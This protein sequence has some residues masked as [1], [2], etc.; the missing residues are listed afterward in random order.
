M[1]HLNQQEAMV[2][3]GTLNGILNAI[4][5]M[6]NPTVKKIRELLESELNRIRNEVREFNSQA[7]H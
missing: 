1:K 4:N 6:D 7:T 2:Y 3:A 5:G